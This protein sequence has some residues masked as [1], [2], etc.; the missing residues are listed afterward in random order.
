MS[1]GTASPIL[2]RHHAINWITKVGLCFNVKRII[3]TFST[4]KGKSVPL[5]GRGAQRIPGS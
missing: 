4:N 3:T 1:Y 2:D 5:Q